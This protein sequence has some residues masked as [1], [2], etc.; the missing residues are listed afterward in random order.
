MNSN[1]PLKKFGLLIRKHR[2]DRH[3]SQDKLAEICGLHRTYI[4]SIERGEQNISLKNIVKL[5]DIFGISV[6]ELFQDW[7]TLE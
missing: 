6:S 1:D 2:K 4:G 3:L 7:D 5:A